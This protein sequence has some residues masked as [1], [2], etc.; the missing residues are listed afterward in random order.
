MQLLKTAPGSFSFGAVFYDALVQFL[1]I[2]PGDFCFGAAFHDA[3]VW[4]SCEALVLYSNTRHR[5]GV[6]GVHG[7]WCAN[8][9]CASVL[10]LVERTG[11]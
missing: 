9:L 11:D 1:N 10:S 2:T 6:Y 4:K 3:P 8:V 5:A 7:V